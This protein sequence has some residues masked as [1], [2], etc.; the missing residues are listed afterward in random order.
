MDALV[1]FFVDLFSGGFFFPLLVLSPIAALISWIVCVVARIKARNSFS[2]ADRK[3]HRRVWI[4][5][6]VLGIVFTLLALVTWAIVL[7]VNDVEAVPRAAAG[8]K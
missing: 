7:N 6:L 5:S 4:V 8:W 3:R 1:D 2:E